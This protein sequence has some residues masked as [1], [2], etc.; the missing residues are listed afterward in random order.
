MNLD[1]SLFFRIG[2]TA[3]VLYLLTHYWT[4]FTALLS[5]VVSAAGPL[6]LGFL[7]AYL[8]NI[9]MSWFERLYFPNSPHPAIK[10]SRR[11]VCL[12][13][14]LAALALIVIWLIQMILP[15]LF[16]CVQ[17][18]AREIP[19]LLNSLYTFLDEQ[20]DLVYLASLFNLETFL[21]LNNI[22]WQ[23][24][25]KQIF[26]WLQT[27]VGGVMASVATLVTT[28]FSNL[29]TA[30]VSMIFALYLLFGKERLT[31]QIGRLV[32]AYTKPSWY[33]KA[34][35]VLDIL[36]DS[37]HRFIVGQCIEAVILGCLCM[38]G[39]RLFSFPYANM[40]GALIGF[41]ALIPIAGAYI[42]ASV[43]AFM[44]FTVSPIK[45]LLFLLFIVILQQLEGNLIYPRVV[46]AS[47]GLP[48]VWV[49]AAI[50]I[51]G[52]LM[53]IAGMLLGVPMA[54][55]CYRLLR[56]DVLRRESIQAPPAP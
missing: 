9:L 54:A 3:F 7:A 10:R 53:G 32:R 5:G 43:G 48:G 42:G 15:E 12:L 6:I 35:A 26:A 13:L 40:V 14:A 22:N 23:D 56:S 30:L 51:G 38:L 47:I 37:F 21:N 1:W 34:K 45:A 11:P 49:L 2:V 16:L 36:N 24:L 20:F 31:G 27:G 55:A 25:V 33:R 28:T 50:T 44:I 41:T 29:V 8:V 19:P 18:L 39:M 52:S 17:L 4:S 46:G